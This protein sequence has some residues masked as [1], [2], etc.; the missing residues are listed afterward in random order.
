MEFEKLYVSIWADDDSKQSNR[1]LGWRSKSL[2]NLLQLLPQQLLQQTPQ[3]RRLTMENSYPE[4]LRR[5]E[6]K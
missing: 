1:T 2:E 6:R 3:Q 4:Y 5:N